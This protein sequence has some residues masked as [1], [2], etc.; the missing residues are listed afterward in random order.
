MA[1]P[2][3]MTPPQTKAPPQA[4]P[5]AEAPASQPP[6]E[7][8]DSPPPAPD[9][10]REVLAPV[11]PRHWIEAASTEPSGLG[12]QLRLSSAYGLASLEQR[13]TWAERCWRQVQDLGY[14]R[15]E[16]VDG[17]G[18]LLGRQA[19]VGSGMILLDPS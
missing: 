16:L 13:R 17:S 15:L 18:Q 11:D 5:T 6:L 8:S 19:L 14:E 10:L 9:P 4:T 2:E 3:A 7:A 1:A 12:L